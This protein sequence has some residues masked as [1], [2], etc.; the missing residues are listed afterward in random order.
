MDHS[1]R[2]LA[3]HPKSVAQDSSPEELEG[4]VP[5]A[6]ERVDEA[7][8]ILEVLRRGERFLVCSH[9]RPDGDAVGSM[10][11]VRMLLEQMGKR[12][13]LVTADQIPMI[14]RKLPGAGEIRSAE[15]VE[16]SYDAAILLEC[17]GLERTKL[18][19]LEQYFL[20]NIDHHA[21]GH[22]YGNLNWIDRSAAS[23][24]ELVYRL[25]QEAGARVTPEMA[26]CLYT[27]LLTDTG[28]F[29][30]GGTQ[31]SSFGLAQELV[32]AGADPLRIAQ[33][34]YFCTPAKKLLLLGAALGNLK[35]EA[36]LS[37]LWVTRRE[38]EQAGAAEEDC[39]GI[40]NFALCVAGVEAAAFLFELPDHRVQVSL[41]SKGR[42]DVAAIAERLG[43][44]GHK[45]A[46]GCT[47]EGSL[48]Q[49]LEKILEQ[50]RPG[51]AELAGNEG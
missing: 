1:N 25:V 45:S 30:Y 49:A 14:H 5:A 33:D 16:G 24:G 13:D 48:E 12:A 19:G 15:R 41:R 22:A 51:V 34:V 32:L 27:T 31:A 38:M 47:M 9:A 3:F 28:G 17:D 36:R 37:W 6:A 26:T 7:A 46:S 23:V 20:I 35:C 39:E 4:V 44:G 50:L 8:E 43:G 2:N 11:A 42:L 18:Q 21:T 40:V 10:L 29:C